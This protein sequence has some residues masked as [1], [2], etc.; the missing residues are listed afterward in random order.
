MNDNTRKDDGSTWAGPVL[1]AAV[2]AG[3]AVLFWWFLSA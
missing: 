3:V 1:F 2:T